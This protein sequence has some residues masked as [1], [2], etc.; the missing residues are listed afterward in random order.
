M[1][2]YLA[3]VLA[4]AGLF[5]LGI[6]PQGISYRMGRFFGLAGYILD[7]RHRKVALENIRTAFPG[8]KAGEAKKIAL[9]SFM[10]FGMV[11]TDYGKA[12]VKGPLWFLKRSEIS[13]SRSVIEYMKKSGK[14]AIMLLAHF[15]VWE[16]LGSMCI[17]ENVNISVIARPLKNRFIDR[18]IKEVREKFPQKVIDKMGAVSGIAGILRKNEIVGIL[19]DQRA[20]GRGVFVDF[21]GKKASTVATPAVLAA[22]T[23]TALFPVFGLRIKNSRFR[24]YV[25]DKIEV[26]DFKG[27]FDEK[28]FGVTQRYAQ[29]VQDEVKKHPGQYFW[30][31]RRWK[32]VPRKGALTSEGR[33]C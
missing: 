6:M 24:L 32:S 13:G 8:I 16:V 15:G 33:I 18:L 20:G 11:I 26:S 7:A 29:V 1:I 10:H 28:V 30:M 5:I 31:H 9:R 21:F 23:D 14:G 12:L 22:K 17:V 2:A 3:Y 25:K 19:A 4:R 27:S